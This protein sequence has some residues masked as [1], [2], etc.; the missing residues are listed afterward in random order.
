[1]ASRVTRVA[2]WF[3]FCGFGSVGLALWVWLYNVTAVRVM[4]A[5]QSCH[6]C[7]TGYMADKRVLPASGEHDGRFGNHY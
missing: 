4:H 1:M 6:T 7:G 3:W 2:L 5:A